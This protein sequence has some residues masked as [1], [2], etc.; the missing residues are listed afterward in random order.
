MDWA[1]F[2]YLSHW[3]LVGFGIVLLWNLLCIR[4]VWQK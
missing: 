3:A 1:H 4:V 2:E